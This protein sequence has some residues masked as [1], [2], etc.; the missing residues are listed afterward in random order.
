MQSTVTRSFQPNTV[1]RM[2]SISLCKGH[3]TSE[4]DLTI[5]FVYASD[6]IFRDLLRFVFV[7]LLNKIFNNHRK[8][9]R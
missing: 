1:S 5:N 2:E 6:R 8:P 4:D 7:I 3:S 9:Q